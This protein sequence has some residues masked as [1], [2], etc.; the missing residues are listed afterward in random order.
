MIIELEK[1]LETAKAAKLE[2][3]RLEVM[4]EK[5]LNHEK[6]VKQLELMR[7]AA[8]KKISWVGV[9]LLAISYASLGYGNLGRFVAGFVVTSNGNPAFNDQKEVAQFLKQSICKGNLKIPVIGK[10]Y[11]AARD[12]LVD[13]LLSRNITSL[14][15]YVK[16]NIQSTAKGGFSLFGWDIS[17]GVVNFFTNMIL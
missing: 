6:H 9:S 17:A 8:L 4:Y 16:R 10:D 7:S 1:R 2:A 13:V 5:L 3:E 11:T 14:R 15:G 12:E